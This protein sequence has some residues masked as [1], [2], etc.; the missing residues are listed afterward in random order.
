LRELTTEAVGRLA[1]FGVVYLS[2]TL[3]V[4][5]FSSLYPVSFLEVSTFFPRQYLWQLTKKK[6]WSG[7]WDHL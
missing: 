3:F 6:W 2:S 4:Q 1:D 5:M 7:C